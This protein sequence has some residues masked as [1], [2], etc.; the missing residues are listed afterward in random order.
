MAMKIPRKPAALGLALLILGVPSGCSGID[1]TLRPDPPTEALRSSLGR[2]GVT[3]R[4]SAD[5]PEGRVPA[6]GSC[7]AAGRGAVVGL[8]VD[9]KVTATLMGVG[10][11]A[12]GPFAILVSGGF[13]ALG[14]GLTPVYALFG[15][16]YGLAAAPDEAALENATAALRKAV[17]ER[18]FARGVAESIL[19][20]ARV[21]VDDPLVPLPPDAPVD[22][23]ETILQIDP[24]QLILNGPYDVNPTLRLVLLQTASLTRVSDHRL[25][26]RIS[27]LH[28]M[29]ENG[30]YLD[31]ARNDAA[32]LRCALSGV[33]RQLGER[34][35]DEMF[36]L[37]GLPQDR[38]WKKELP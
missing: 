12:T 8:I 37:H 31:W 27:F 33:D 24:P 23:I 16:L 14:I 7:D 5:G 1:P 17:L 11:A 15:S 28:P 9:G 4:D 10:A 20:R 19:A 25:L 3:W 21:A 22:G 13:L 36:L 34:L 32:M 2:V 30:C 18:Q 29:R 6:K 38:E 35:L 26:Y